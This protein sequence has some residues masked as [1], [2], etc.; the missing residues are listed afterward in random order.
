MIRLLLLALCCLLI[1][2][3]AASAESRS[4]SYSV[5]SVIDETVH[6]RFVI[7]E[8]EARR[9]ADP[10]APPPTNQA[11]ADYIAAHVAVSSAGGS[12]P[13]IDQGDEIGLVYALA[14]VPGLRRFEIIFQCPQPNGITLQNSVLFDRIPSHLNF[15]RIQIGEAAP[16]D[17]VFTSAHESVALSAPPSQQSGAGVLA[18][19]RLGATHIVNS[20]DRICFVLAFLLLRSRREDI[21]YLVGGISLGYLISLAITLSGI[22]APRMEFTEPLLGLM[23]VLVAVDAAAQASKRPWAAA[24]LLG[25]GLLALAV[26]TAVLHGMPAGLVLTGI[27]VFAVCYLPISSELSDRAAFALVPTTLFGMLDGFGFAST[28]SVLKLPVETLVPLQLA[29]DVGALLVIALLASVIVA[30]AGALRAR[31]QTTWP[32]SADL[33]SAALTALGVFWFVSRLYIS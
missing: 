27:A 12:C 33:A 25:T 22:I 4:V 20:L 32:L 3:Q 19:M 14:P 30:I 31:G 15:A 24:A 29:F 28:L 18:Y 26:V 6:A 11:I 23:V 8:A 10:G 1:G 17:Q 9:L 5:W 16:V 2:P 13:A 21:G 7:P